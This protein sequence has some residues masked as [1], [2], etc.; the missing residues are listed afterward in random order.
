MPRQT[1]RETS[2]A[3][4]A[5]GEYPTLIANPKEQVEFIISTRDLMPISD[6]S[7][8]ERIIDDV[9]ATNAINIEEIKAGNAKAI[10][11]LVAQAMKATNGKAKP[12]Q[13][14]ELLTKKLA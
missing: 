6:S 5:V 1:P 14:N 4:H 8:L 12:A 11:A 13:V 3:N 2:K 10:N 9:L 7:E